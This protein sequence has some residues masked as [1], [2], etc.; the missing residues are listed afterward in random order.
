MKPYRTNNLRLLL[1]MEQCNP[2]WPSVPL[3]AFNLF[4]HLRKLT[5]VTL[6]THARNEA[7]LRARCPDSSIDFIPESKASARWFRLV[8]R[9]TSKG[10]TNWPLQHALSY[11]I[12]EEFNRQ[13]Y[14]R[15][16]EPVESGQFDAVIGATPI[17]PRYPYS[18]AKA[19]R[20]VPFILGPVNG[21][22]PFPRGFEKIA[23]REFAGFNFLRHIGRLIPGYVDTYRRADRILS[24]SEF[25]R[26]W[27]SRALEIPGEKIELMAENGIG[28]AFFR[29][30]LETPDPGKPLRVVFAGR[31]VPYK[32]ADM[33]VEAVAQASQQVS[34]PIELSV[35]GD[36]PERP[37]LEALIQEHG[38]QDRVTL[39]GYVP[40]EE[41]PA[42]FAEAD[43]F[44]FPSIREFG[45]AVALEAMASGLPCIVADHGGIGEYVTEGC[46]WKIPVQSRARLVEQTASALCELASRPRLHEAMARNARERAREYTWEAKVERLLGIVTEAIAQRRG[47]IAAAA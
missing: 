40:P 26:D 1:V 42:R 39:T 20:D 16:R 25:T 41:M 23:S 36:G 32:G 12:Y 18:I 14:Q 7:A 10:G 38:I 31:L 34:R 8:H 46:G 30:P 5:D 35:I 24:G 37:H 33:V 44:A 17:L 13:V 27:I 22:L 29:S 3:V 9:L 47:P 21:G 45:G 11:P 28:K 4:D 15:Y 19:C 43:V 2:D 6:V